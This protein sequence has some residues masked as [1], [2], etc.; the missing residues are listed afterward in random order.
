MTTH[1][2]AA[3]LCFRNNNSLLSLKQ[4]CENRKQS[5]TIY[6]MMSDNTF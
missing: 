5:I 1:F 4:W 3:F 6:D 2:A